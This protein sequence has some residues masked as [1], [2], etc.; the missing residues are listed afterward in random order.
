MSQEEVERSAELLQKLWLT[1]G[2]K[3]CQESWQAF[4]DIISSLTESSR[5]SKGSNFCR[6][7][8]P[9]AAEAAA[10]QGVHK[11]FTSQG[12]SGSLQSFS[13][14]S[15]FLQVRSCQTLTCRK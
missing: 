10:C 6:A 9:S 7:S 1:A 2:G 5:G 14:V 3:I 8:D 13:T 15:G 12:H 11:A 4:K